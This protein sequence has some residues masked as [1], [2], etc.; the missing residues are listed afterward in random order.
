MENQYF[1]GTVQNRLKKLN[2]L[3][4]EQRNTKTITL[5]EKHQRSIEEYLAW[6]RVNN[7]LVDLNINKQY[8]LV[9]IREEQDGNNDFSGDK[10]AEKALEL[11][12]NKEISRPAKDAYNMV[13]R[14]VVEHG[15][16][17]AGLTNLYV[18][19]VVEA[20]QKLEYV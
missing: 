5:Y 11:L 18:R 12:D 7:V 19:E 8:V 4:E 16:G 9:E 17:N 14:I 6:F 15:P 1:I 3:I 10:I 2:S 13:L 20:L